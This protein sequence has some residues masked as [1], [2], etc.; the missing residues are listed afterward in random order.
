MI[1]TN[2]K[3]FKILLLAVA[4]FAA[5]TLSGVNKAANY[6]HLSIRF[7]ERNISLENDSLLLKEHNKII[8]QALEYQLLADSLNRLARL[9]RN[10]LK[11]TSD[12]H[13]RIEII[14]EISKLEQESDRYQEKA[15]AMYNSSFIY[16]VNR[17]KTDTVQEKI[18]LVSEINGIKVYRYVPDGYE[19]DSYDSLIGSS[20][21]DKGETYPAQ[22]KEKKVDRFNIMEVSPYNDL[23]PI[24][25]D[26]KLPEGLIF[27][28]QLGVYSKPV[29][30]NTFK[31]LSPLSSMSTNGRTKYFAG[32]F[33]SS[34]S[35]GKAL[36]DIREYGF[37]DAFIVSFYNGKAIKI[38]RAKEI[39]YSQIKL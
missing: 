25:S 28:I 10:F 9:K 12:P 22:K 8:R 1:Y 26:I 33:Y 34:N 15:D 19:Y 17:G 13:K 18:R 38:E 30:N 32:I 39:E 3:R 5:R 35:A 20:A 31:G 23:N 21:I 2:L 7:S 27:R 11:E 29:P 4:L 6:S 14:S 24:P 37:P 36:N 16:N